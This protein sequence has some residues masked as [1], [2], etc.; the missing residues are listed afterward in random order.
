MFKRFSI[1]FCIWKSNRFF[2]IGWLSPLKTGAQSKKGVKK[3]IWHQN[4]NNP[5]FNRA[6]INF[7][8]P[9]VNPELGAS[10]NVVL[11]WPL[12]FWFLFTHLF[13]ILKSPFLSQNRIFLVNFIRIQWFIW[14]LVLVLF[15]SHK[16][17]VSGKILVFGNILGFPG[18]ILP[19]NVPKPSTLGTSRFCLNTQFWKIVYILSLSY[20]RLPLVEISANLCHIRGER[21]QKLA[22]RVVVWML[23]RHK[24]IWTYITWQPH[25]LN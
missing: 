2:S 1:K 13:F 24:N 12:T 10:E 5:S 25:M 21:A 8:W 22:K 18:I 11:T 7:F 20:E 15:N 16:D 3:E 9:I 23:Y 14:D 17:V 4:L 6:T 19:K